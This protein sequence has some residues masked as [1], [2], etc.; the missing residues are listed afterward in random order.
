MQPRLGMVVVN[1]KSEGSLVRTDIDEFFAVRCQF[2]NQCK[3]RALGNHV[4]KLAE[5]ITGLVQ[6]NETAQIRTKSK[7]GDDKIVSLAKRTAHELGA[8]AFEQRRLPRWRCYRRAGKQP[9]RP[10][11]RD[12]ACRR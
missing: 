12:R 10:R 9:A 11:W 1:E 3:G 8:G 4:L 6:R 2:P 7:I 5:R